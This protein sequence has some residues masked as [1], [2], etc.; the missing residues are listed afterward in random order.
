MKHWREVLP[1]GV[2]LDVQYE[3]LVGD[4]EP[5]ACRSLLIAASNGTTP[6]WPFTRPSGWCGRPA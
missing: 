2:M 6:A 1:E 5:Q 4:F 3:E